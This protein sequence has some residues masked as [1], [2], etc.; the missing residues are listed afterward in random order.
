MVRTHKNKSGYKINDATGRFVHIEQAEK[1][2]G[3]RIYAGYEVHHKNENNTDNRIDNLAV[4]SKP[5]HRAIHKK[6]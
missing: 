1:K 5:L 6:K 3:G 2:V 4:V